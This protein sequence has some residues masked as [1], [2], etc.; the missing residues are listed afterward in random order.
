MGA[1]DFVSEDTPELLKNLI[2]RNL[3][4]PNDSGIGFDV[5]T[6]FEASK[7]LFILGPLLAGNVIDDKP[8]WHLEHCGRIIWSSSKMAQKWAKKAK[9]SMFSTN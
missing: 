7:D 1:T 9:L 3:L 6:D 5:N 2:E 8:L 4:I